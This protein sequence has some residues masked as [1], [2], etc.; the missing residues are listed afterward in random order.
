MSRGARR[1]PTTVWVGAA[2]WD[3]ERHATQKRASWL[4]KPDLPK[5]IPVMRLKDP[6]IIGYMVEYVLLYLLSHR[7]A[8]ATYQQ[9]R[10]ERRWQ[11]HI[12]PHPAQVRVA[13]L[14]LRS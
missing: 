11:V 1:C 10:A 9:Q 12:P 8:Q 13:V 3:T 6:G 2:A 14:G 4:T 5:G 7:R